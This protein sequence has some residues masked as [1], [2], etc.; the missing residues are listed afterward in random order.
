MN[1]LMDTFFSLQFE[2]TMQDVGCPEIFA[3]LSCCHRT[4]LT[5]LLGDWLVQS[6][7]HFNSSNNNVYMRLIEVIN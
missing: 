7:G 2:P 3:W 4:L 5:T 6:F 1:I